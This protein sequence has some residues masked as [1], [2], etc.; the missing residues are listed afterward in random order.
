MDGM[1]PPLVF[2]VDGDYCFSSCCVMNLVNVVCCLWNL[3][4]REFILSMYNCHCA[5][6]LANV[7]EWMIFVMLLQPNLIMSQICSVDYHKNTSILFNR[8]VT[9][10]VSSFEVF[11]PRVPWNWMRWH[12]DWNLWCFFKK[13]FWGSFCVLTGVSWCL[14]LQLRLLQDQQRG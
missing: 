13:N 4:S 5:S 8:L 10:I 1:H 11:H 2:F 3:S 9:L 6:K 7:F 12:Q 14:V